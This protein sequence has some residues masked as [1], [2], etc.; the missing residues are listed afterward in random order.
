MRL[1][2][3]VRVTA[4]GVPS[5]SGDR[6]ALLWVPSSAEEAG[7][8]G[9]ARWLAPPALPHRDPAAAPDAHANQG[10]LHWAAGHRT[11]LLTG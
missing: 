1:Q 3:A 9:A 7:E 11:Q 5:C 10:Y 8:A 2:Q 6:E 4:S